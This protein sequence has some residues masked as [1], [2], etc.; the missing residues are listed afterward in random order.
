[1]MKDRKYVSIP[2]ILSILLL[3]V[4]LPACNK[5][6]FPASGYFPDKYLEKAIRDNIGKD[7]HEVITISDL[8]KIVSL[9]ASFY[10]I[11]DLSGLELL[12]NLK[13]FSIGGYD[14][15]SGRISD[16]DDISILA[17]LHNLTSISL[18][19]LPITDITPLASLDNLTKLHIGYVIPEAMND[20]FDVHPAGDSFQWSYCKL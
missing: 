4:S 2:V 5:Q 6:D 20:I 9:D 15:H 13:E 7:S 17:S 3:L 11:N 10:G 16:V 14:N 19:E 18:Y 1:M 12:T 8:E